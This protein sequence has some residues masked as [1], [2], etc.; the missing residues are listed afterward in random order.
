MNRLEVSPG[1]TTILVDSEA[2][3]L[4]T[5]FQPAMEFQSLPSAPEVMKL[6][7]PWRKKSTRRRS[8]SPPSRRSIK[9]KP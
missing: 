8:T 3:M 7:R 6:G 4:M 5:G 1:L 2:T 9:I